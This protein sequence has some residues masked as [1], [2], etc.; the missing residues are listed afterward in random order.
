MEPALMETVA[1]P[2]MAISED[3]R[4][5]RDALVA[6]NLETPI[7]HNGLSRDQKYERIKDAFADIALTLGLDLSVASWAA[8]ACEFNCGFLLLLLPTSE[9]C[10][11]Q[12]NMAR[13]AVCANT[14]Y[15]NLQ[16]SPNLGLLAIDV[17]R[18]QVW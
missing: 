1:R 8:L 13:K 16:N 2:T 4:R 6:R 18:L 15:F 3:A 17:Y 14:I 5:V 12:F 9:S 10:F 11:D 7:F